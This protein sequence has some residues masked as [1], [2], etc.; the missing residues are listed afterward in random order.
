MPPTFAAPPDRPWPAM[1]SPRLRPAQCTLVSSSP[2]LG[3]GTG[4]SRNST[5]VASLPLT[6]NQDFM[7]AILSGRRLVQRAVLHDQPQFHVILQDADVLQRIA[8]HQQQVRQRAF[9]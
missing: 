8:V 7:A 2:G 4:T 1:N 5:E 9:A 6:M 3:S